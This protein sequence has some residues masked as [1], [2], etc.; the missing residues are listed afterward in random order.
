[1]ETISAAFDDMNEDA[2]RFISN[3]ERMGE[4]LSHYNNIID[5]TGRKALGVSY[6][7]MRILG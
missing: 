4:T 6:E 3:N 5:L 1:M 7:Q 2:E